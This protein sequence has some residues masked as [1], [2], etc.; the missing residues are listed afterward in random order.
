MN[1]N[2]HYIK[3]V[4]D[5]N[6]TIV[7][8]ECTLRDVK[9]DSTDVIGKNWFDTFIDNKDK[10]TVFKVFTNLLNWQ[11]ATWKTYENDIKCLD[12][13]HKFIDFENEIIIKDGE[14]FI[15]S[16]GVEHMDNA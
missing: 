4:L 12:G 6:A 7:K 1:K 5:K 13:K 15:S 2:Q 8:F 10:E 11:T 3:V 14:K 16:Y 9:P